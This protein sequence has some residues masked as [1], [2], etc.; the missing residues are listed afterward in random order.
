MGLPGNGMAQP[1]TA[2]ASANVAGGGHGE[3][4]LLGSSQ[5][6]PG[7]TVHGGTKTALVS[8]VCPSPRA[9]VSILCP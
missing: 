2:F 8:P 4:G 1:V 9:S 7:E 3:L 6:L 5:M